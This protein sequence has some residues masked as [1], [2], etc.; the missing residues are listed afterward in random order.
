MGKDYSKLKYLNTENFNNNYICNEKEVEEKY[1]EFLDWLID[2][3]E[4][5]EVLNTTINLQQATFIPYSFVDLLFPNDSLTRYNLYGDIYSYLNTRKIELTHFNDGNEK[6]IFSKLSCSNQEY[7][8]HKNKLKKI[9]EEIQQKLDINM[10]KNNIAD[11]SR[12]I[13]DLESENSSIL[14]K[15]EEQIQLNNK[16]CQRILEMKEE[17]FKDEKIDL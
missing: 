4:K 17:K 7:Y 16:L 5:K 14:K 6:K 12:R 10:C 11:M 9:D 2:D 13:F 1:K 15:L 3:I 8:N